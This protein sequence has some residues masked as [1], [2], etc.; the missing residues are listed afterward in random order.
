MDFIKKIFGLNSKKSQ[1]KYEMENELKYW[2]ILEIKKDKKI[3]IAR[4][5]IQ[6]PDYSDIDQYKEAVVIGWSWNSQDDNLKPPDDVNEKQLVFE[7]ALDDLTGDNNL[8]YL[9]QVTTGLGHKEWVFYT[10]DKDEFMQIFNSLLEGYEK[11]PIDIKFY[12]DPDWKI[13]TEYL[14]LYK[15][16]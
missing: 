1:K 13:W 9:I 15:K 5:R 8:S 3:L 2:K 11:F 7:R 10:K 6:K 16:P 14:D 12:N 4:I